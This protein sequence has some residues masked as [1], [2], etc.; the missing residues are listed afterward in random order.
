MPLHF[1][2]EIVERTSIRKEDVIS[3]LQHLNL[4]HYYKGQYV[5]CLTP[6]VIHG[7]LR[8]MKK[9]RHRI[10]GKCISWTPKD[11]TRRGKW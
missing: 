11:W 4:I 10:D 8:A 2:S 9:R 7:H 6:E 1:Y 3:T 5:I